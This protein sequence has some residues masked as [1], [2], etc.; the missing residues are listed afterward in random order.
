MGKSTG[1][2]KDKGKGHRKTK[3]VCKKGETR[4]RAG[5][6]GKAREHNKFYHSAYANALREEDT[7]ERANARARLV[8]GPSWTCLT[9][10]QCNNV[11]MCVC[12]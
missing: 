11:V 1:K 5:G 10:L 9:E 12:P 2:G 3:V 8:R 6:R 4:A 7:S